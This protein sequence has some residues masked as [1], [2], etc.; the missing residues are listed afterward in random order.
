MIDTNLTDAQIVDTE[1]R[2][3]R[4]NAISYARASVSLEGFK[5]SEACEHQAARFIAGA[6]DLPEFLKQAR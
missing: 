5:P 2:R 4:L 1:Q 3:K 6:I